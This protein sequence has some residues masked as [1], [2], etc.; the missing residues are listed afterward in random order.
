MV[1]RWDVLVVAAT[2]LGGSM[3]IES[4][5]RV[6]TGAP[7]D[8]FAAAPLTACDDSRAYQAPGLTRSTEPGNDEGYSVSPSDDVAPGCASAND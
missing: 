6:D 4:S 7:D 5:H 1:P 8:A 3:M 2:L